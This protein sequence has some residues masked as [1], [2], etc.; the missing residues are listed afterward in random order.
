MISLRNISMNSSVM[1]QGTWALQRH[2][3]LCGTSTSS[4]SIGMTATEAGILARYVCKVEVAE[5]KELNSVDDLVFDEKVAGTVDS[6]DMVSNSTVDL[7]VD[8]LITAEDDVSAGS[9]VMV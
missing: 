5:V 9:T 3:Q 6:D 1:F 7:A 4:P 8:D 2:P